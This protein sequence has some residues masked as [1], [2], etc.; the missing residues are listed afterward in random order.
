MAELPA[1]SVQTIR[2]LA[3]RVLAI[4]VLAIRVLAKIFFMSTP[5]RKATYPA[6]GCS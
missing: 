4:R 6:L 5:W 1:K 3:I 2:V